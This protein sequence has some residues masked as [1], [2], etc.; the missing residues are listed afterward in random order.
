MHGAAR[1]APRQPRQE[2]CAGAWGPVATTALL[3]CQDYESKLE[4]LQKQMDSRYFPEMNEEEDEPEDEGMDPPVGRQA[5]LG[6]RLGEVAERVQPRAVPC[7]SAV[8]GPPLS[9]GERL[10]HHWEAG[11]REAVQ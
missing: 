8:W 2:G 7:R 9:L 1:G 11:F 5:V 3:L 10:P 6:L 4:A